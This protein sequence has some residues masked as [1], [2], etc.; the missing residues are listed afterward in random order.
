M[1]TTTALF[2]LFTLFTACSDDDTSPVN[3]VQEETGTLSE[4]E[5]DD[6]LFLREEEKLAR[7]VYLFSYDKYGDAV[8]NSI[9]QSE[10]QHMDNVLGLLVKYGINDPA[11]MQRGLFT[12]STLQTIYDDLTA[13]SDSSLLDA[14]EVGAII[15][16]LDIRDLD[17]NMLNTTKQD[18]L[19]SY[20]L[21]Q[22]GSRNHMRSF[23]KKLV[24]AGFNY[25]P[26]FISSA[27]YTSIINSP[28][29]KCGI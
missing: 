9:S 22:C 23:T 10:Q 27:N 15:E 3:N 5:K 1:K 2:L 25:V 21:L 7:D 19:D 8:F 13:K 12:N 29:E 4:Q 17:L 24:A 14:L 16:D 28:N 20:T 6:L 11:S 26:Q 18:L